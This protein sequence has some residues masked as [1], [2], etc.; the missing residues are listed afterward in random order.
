MYW[1]R[2]NLVFVSPSVFFGTPEI[3]DFKKLFHGKINY[4]VQHLGPPVA[5]SL[6]LSMVLQRKPWGK[7]VGADASFQK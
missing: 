4:E 2:T 6:W 3:N 1:K 5:N 7:D